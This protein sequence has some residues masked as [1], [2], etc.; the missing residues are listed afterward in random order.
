MT[1][2][3]TVRAMTKV[4]GKFPAGKEGARGG[5]RGLRQLVKAYALMFPMA[6]SKV[7]GNIITT[8]IC[9]SKG[10]Q[11]LDDLSTHQDVEY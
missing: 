8:L 5:A 10:S 9:K 1:Y 4:E 11:E 6:A 2:D 3:T 7:E